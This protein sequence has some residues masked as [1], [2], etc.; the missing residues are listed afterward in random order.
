MP[1][2]GQIL[3]KTVKILESPQLFLPTKDML[4]E[5]LLSARNMFSGLFQSIFQQNPKKQNTTFSRGLTCVIVTPI[6][7]GH[8]K[9]AIEAERSINQAIAHSKGPF[10]DIFFFPID[11]SEAKLGRSAARNIAVQQLLHEDFDWVFF[12]DADDLLLP[13]T[14]KTVTKYI[15]KYNAIWGAIAVKEKESDQVTLRSPQYNVKTI[16]E[17]VILPPYAT[18]QMGHFVKIHIAAKYPFDE[19]RNTGEDYDYYLRVWEK[20]KCIKITEQPFF[21]NRR[22]L[23]SVGTRSATGQEWNIAIQKLQQEYIKKL[24]ITVKEAKLI[25]IKVK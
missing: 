13:T 12:L 17:L 3:Q 14:F 16:K 15:N 19:K 25:S 24:K 5:R 4:S 20:E 8:E 22:G 21:I 10:S 6:G 2:N 23:H 7:P 1:V 18:L 9:L 11:D